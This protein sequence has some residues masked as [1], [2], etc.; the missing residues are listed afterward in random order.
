MK[1]SSICAAV[2]LAALC[3]EAN[4]DIRLEDGDHFLSLIT[5]GARHDDNISQ[6]PK[7]QPRDA[8][9]IAVIQPA[10]LFKAEGSK[11]TLDGAYTLTHEAYEYDS[12]DDHTDHNLLLKTEFA[13]TARNKATLALNYV[14][15]QDIRTSINRSDPNEDVG[16][17]SSFADLSG[18]YR[19]GADSG[20]AQLEASLGGSQLRYSNN[21]DT[22]SKNRIKER[23]MITPGGT[24]YL[25]VAPKTRL[26]LEVARTD[27]DYLDS[28]SQL[29]NNATK[30][31]AGVI[32][33]ATAKTTGYIRYGQEDKNFDSENAID[34]SEPAWDVN[35]TWQPRSY[36]RLNITTGQGSAEGSVRS[37]AIE[38]TTSTLSWAHNWYYNLESTLSY[39]LIKE[40]YK[41]KVFDGREEDTTT[42]SAALAYKI[43]RNVELSGSYSH[44]NRE[45][46]SAI[47]EFNSNIV[48]LSLTLAM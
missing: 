26:L 15:Q 16:D 25:R 10:F 32:W 44:I 23:D 9:A 6:A 7:S 35:I 48:E 3:S 47:E 11:V 21:L 30:Y 43:S 5:V 46:N 18:Q 20:R 37:D 12:K 1:S 28:E 33:E 29:N 4:S 34:T 40:E 31:Y 36:S 17:R 14:K 38:T 39:N 42:A 41:G 22:L 24:F 45:S 13:F 19:I 27:F 8:S 2:V